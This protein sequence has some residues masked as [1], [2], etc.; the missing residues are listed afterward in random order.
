MASTPVTDLGSIQARH[1]KRLEIQQ[2]MAE[3]ERTHYSEIIQRQCRK[4]RQLEKEI[5]CLKKLLK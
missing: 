5:K 3:Y 4:I 2:R 1:I